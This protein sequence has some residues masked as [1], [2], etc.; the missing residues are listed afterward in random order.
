M[1]GFLG[2]QGVRVFGL[3][4]VTK[5]FWG[6]PASVA[7]AAGALHAF[8]V[9]RFRASDGFTAL[10]RRSCYYF[11]R[12]S[13]GCYGTLNPKPCCESILMCMPLKR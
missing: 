12:A 2:P 11:R 6:I 5:G 4:G 8:V 7:S 1:V 10:I 3:W 13:L 9:E